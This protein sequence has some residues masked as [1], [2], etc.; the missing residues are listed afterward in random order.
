MNIHA[1]FTPASTEV[2]S[3]AGPRP[4]R[5]RHGLL[6]SVALISKPQMRIRDADLK[7]PNVLSRG[8]GVVN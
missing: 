8:S 4:F 1:G 7:S 5:G 6:Q 2:A 3:L